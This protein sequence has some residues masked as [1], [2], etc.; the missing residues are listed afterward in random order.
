[1]PPNAVEIQLNATD[2]ASP[3]INQAGVELDKYGY[4]IGSAM[5][6]SMR[7]QEEM[8]RAIGSFK[9][10]GEEV[11]ATEAPMVAAGEETSRLEQRFERLTTASSYAEMGITRLQRMI[12]GM[13]FGTV[14][15]AV[16]ALAS[17]ILNLGLHSDKARQDLDALIKEVTQEADAWDL[18][19]QR[20][21]KV[22]ESTVALYNAKLVYAQFME[23]N[24]GKNI[25]KEIANL[26]ERNEAIRQGLEL[27]GNRQII[28]PFVTDNKILTEE[29]LKNNVA[30]EQ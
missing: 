23:A 6:I 20:V 18:H 21:D 14:V 22:T 3:V 8:E 9:N 1:M 12:T 11:A 26:Q 16:S 4:R 30:I 7:Q 13:A 10:L 17:E 2:S 5:N 15:G 25:Q 29:L 19:R 28:G 27:M 24:E